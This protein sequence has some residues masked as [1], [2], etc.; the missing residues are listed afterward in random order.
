M[1]TTGLGV[2]APLVD[3]VSGVASH[4][5]GARVVST[6]PK[7]ARRGVRWY[8]AEY[9]DALWPEDE[10]EPMR[11]WLEAQLL[12]PP[13][14]CSFPDLKLSRRLDDEA[15]IATLERCCPQAAQ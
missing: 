8:R 3:C 6:S 5:G 15:T 9:A 13:V 10:R 12:R 11:A 1:G 14:P 2:G 7:R 4:R